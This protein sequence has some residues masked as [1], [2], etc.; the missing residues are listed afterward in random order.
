GAV[1]PGTIHLGDLDL[2]SFTADA[3]DAIVVRAGE[4]G[5]DGNF[6]PWLRVYGPSGTL[7]GA[8]AADLAAEVVATAQESGTF[9]VVVSDGYLAHAGDSYG[10]TGTYNLN[11]ATTAGPFTTSNGDEGG[12][13]INGTVTPGTIHLGDLD[14]W[15]FTA[16]PGDA[17]V[18]RAG[19]V[20]DAGNF[21]PW[22]RL[23]GP[24]GTLL[25]A[26]AA[27]L[28][29]EVVTT[30]PEGGTFL[31]VVSDGYLAHSGDSYGNTGTYRLHLATTA[32]DFTTSVNDEGGPLT[33]GAVT[34]GTIHLG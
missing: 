8:N 15:S 19:E 22:V 5:D 32:T 20:A 25:G 7:L 16:S 13:L 10:N 31:V 33:N 2:W 12:A 28:A 26:N 18:V 30:A 23:Y 34:P 27:D 9:L 14:L 24:S 3:G 1:T 4:V 21:E 17:I 6:E 11:L 29:A